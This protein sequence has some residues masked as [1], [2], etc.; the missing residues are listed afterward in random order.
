[1]GVWIESY[2]DLYYNDNR[3]RVMKYKSIVLIGP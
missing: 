2:L 1:M 3:K